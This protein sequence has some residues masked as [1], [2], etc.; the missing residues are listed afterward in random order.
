MTDY[1]ELV[2]VALDDDSTSL[3][4]TSALNR[5]EQETYLSTFRLGL[6]TNFTAVDLLKSLRA[7]GY[8][9]RVNVEIS[10]SNYNDLTSFSVDN[11][12]TNAVLIVYIFDNLNP[13]LESFSNDEVKVRACVSDFLH[14]VDVFIAMQSPRLILVSDFF[15]IRDENLF[16]RDAIAL[17]NRMLDEFCEQ[18]QQVQKLPESVISR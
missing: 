17:A 11:T 3:Q 12:T 15:T 16:S 9:S 4:R 5:L 1:D 14:Q 8:Y 6:A 18:R 10:K 7:Y 13:L 2:E